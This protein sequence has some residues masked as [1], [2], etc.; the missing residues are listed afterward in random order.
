[1]DVIDKWSVTQ[2]VQS[3][4]YILA[5]QL[6]GTDYGVGQV[7]AATATAENCAA[8][9]TKVVTALAEKGVLSLDDI[10]QGRYK[11]VGAPISND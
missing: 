3:L 6:D 7:E 10:E 5:R 2:D 4:E 11:R 1:M 8:L 9:L